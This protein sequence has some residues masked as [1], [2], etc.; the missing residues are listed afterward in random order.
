MP[1]FC[2]ICNKRFVTSPELKNHLII[3]T[4]ERNHK[5]NTCNKAFGTKKTLLTHIKI[6][7]GEKNYVCHVCSKAFT[8][9][10]VLRKHFKMHPGC[11]IPPPGSVLS[12]KAQNKKNLNEH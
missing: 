10:H 8:Q 12:K 1:H 7:T 6:H 3:H 4:K 11:T 9:A 5:C 2:T